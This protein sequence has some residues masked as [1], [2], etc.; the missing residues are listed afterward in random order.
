MY[1]TTPITA[2][3]PTTNSKTFSCRCAKCPRSIN[4]PSL[5]RADAL[6][7]KRGSSAR[8]VA[9]CGDAVRCITLLERV[10]QCYDETRTGGADGMAKRN[11]APMHVELIARN[12]KLALE[13]QVVERERFV[14][15]KQLEIAQLHLQLLE[16]L[17]HGRYGRLGKAPGSARGPGTAENLAQRSKLVS[18]DGAL[19]RQNNGG[20]SIGNLTGVAGR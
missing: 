18:V 15:L 6:Q 8:A 20:G 9:Q 14:V 1:A 4:V 12:A 11:G 10:E 19:A 2:S 17:A 13:K 5:E 7:R 3:T 16:Q